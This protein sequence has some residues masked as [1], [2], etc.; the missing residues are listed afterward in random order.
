MSLLFFPSPHRVGEGW[1]EGAKV[2]MIMCQRS[3]RTSQES[4]WLRFYDGG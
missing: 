3:I 1:D 2:V 4:G